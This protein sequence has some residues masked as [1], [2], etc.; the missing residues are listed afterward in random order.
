MLRF[1]DGHRYGAGQRHGAMIGY[2]MDGNLPNALKSVINQIHAQRVVLKLRG[3]LSPSVLVA[4][5]PEAHQSEHDRLAD[6]LT[7]HHLLLCV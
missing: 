5:R 6:P 7:L 3:R 4:G 2:V 1:F